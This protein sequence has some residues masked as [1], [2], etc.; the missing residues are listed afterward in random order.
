MQRVDERVNFTL[1]T[2]WRERVVIRQKKQNSMRNAIFHSSLAHKWK[3]Q[4]SEN[5]LTISLW[6]TFSS[7]LTFFLRVSHTGRHL[8]FCFFHYISR[9][10]NFIPFSPFSAR[11]KHSARLLFFSRWSH[12]M[13]PLLSCSVGDIYLHRFYATTCKD[14]KFT[15]NLTPC[16]LSG[17]TEFHT[18][19]PT[20]QKIWGTKEN[21][22]SPGGFMICI[23]CKSYQYSFSDK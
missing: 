21:L 14:I 2:Q 6:L 7:L 23:K 11:R 13:F 5:S 3:R 8:S 10:S 16:S 12:S 1:S 19:L 9:D 20:E 17:S 4:S 18:F 15:I 22:I